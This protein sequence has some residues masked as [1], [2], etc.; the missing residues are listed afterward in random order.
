MRILVIGL[1]LVA[2]GCDLLGDDKTPGPG[3]VDTI[4]Y[5]RHIQPVFNNRCTSC[6]AGDAASAGLRLDTWQHVIAGSSHGEALI[7]FDAVHSRMIRLLENTADTPHPLNAGGDNLSPDEL[8]LLKRWIDEGARN[9]LGN[10]PYEQAGD[11]IYVANQGDRTVSVIDPSFLVVA[12]HFHLD[13]MGYSDRSAPAH[14]AVEPDGSL[15]YVSLTGDN[16]VVKLTRGGAVLGEVPVE[17]PELLALNPANGRVYAGRALSVVTPASSIAEIRRSDMS[18]TEIPVVFPRP[19]ALALNFTT[20]ALFSASFD[21]DQFFS[22]STGSREVTISSIEGPSRAFIQF[23]VRPGEDELWATGQLSDQITVYDISN[24]LA[25]VQRQSV[26]VASD[27]WHLTFTPDGTRVY[28][29]NKGADRVTVFRANTATI[30]AEIEGPGLAQ[31]HGV[32]VSR[33]GRHVFVSNRNEDGAYTSRH[34][35]GQ[36]HEPGTVVV[37]DTATNT[38]VKVLEVGREPAGMGSSVVVPI[39]TGN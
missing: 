8:A 5:S 6:H 16:K 29:A 37:I 25:I 12:R 20:N 17:H 22:V 39:T 10:A 2:S 3:Q 34:A 23:A 15:W 1:L 19:H 13:D 7:A 9:D 26:D 35:T 31:P 14:V 38:I 32:A 33:D 18:A 36:L 30:L 4:V 21:V 28:V 27:P 24:P 11:Q